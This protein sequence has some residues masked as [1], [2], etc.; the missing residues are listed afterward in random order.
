MIISH[1][2]DLNALMAFH[3]P[4]TMTTVIGNMSKAS[5]I[6]SNSTLL[7]VDMNKLNKS[8]GAGLDKLSS[9][10]IR[11]CAD[12]I[13]PYISTIFNCLTTGLFPDD[14]KLVKVTPI[15][16]RPISVISATAKVGENNF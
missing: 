1:Q 14:W 15:C 3:Y 8:K 2:L 5:T 13:S 7:I 9:R 12:L 11:E 16:D 4:I 6:D 10:L